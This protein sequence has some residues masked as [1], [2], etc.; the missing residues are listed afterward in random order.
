MWYNGKTVKYV[1]AYASSKNCHAI[2]NGIPELPGWLS[3]TPTSTDGVTNVISILTAAV[4]SGRSVNV[5][6]TS[7][8]ITAVYMA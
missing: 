5:E 2:M 1:S 8:T 7:N 3:I 4:A 6:I